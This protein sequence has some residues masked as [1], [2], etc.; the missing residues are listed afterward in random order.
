MGAAQPQPR[1]HARFNLRSSA[2]ICGHFFVRSRAY[3][4]TR[5]TTA[6]RLVPLELAVTVP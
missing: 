1:L 3:R 4:T 5:M 6:L 2:Q